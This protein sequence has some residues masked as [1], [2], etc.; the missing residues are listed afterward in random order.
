MLHDMF[1]K[2]FDLFNHIIEP[3]FR[4]P[5]HVMD[6]FNFVEENNLSMILAP[7]EHLKTVFLERYTLWKIIN[8]PNIR[9][10]LVSNTSSLAK[11]IATYPS[12]NLIEN[13]RLV[14]AF[15][16]LLDYSGISSEEFTVNR[17]TTDRNPTLYALGCFGACVGRRFDLIIVDD[18]LDKRSNSKISRKIEDWIFSELF[19]CLS[20][21]GQIVIMGTRKNKGDLY[22]RI[23]SSKGYIR[24]KIDKAI[25]GDKL[26][27]PE[28]WSMEKLMKRKAEIG[29]KSFKLD[30]LNEVR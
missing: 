24:A 3:N 18:V 9:I 27:W 22:G 28:H 8:N 26:L 14:A 19:G 7:R 13:D 21:T 30:F 11:N 17:N 6:W 12:S 29:E 1:K 2:D 15:G 10:S 25:V 5:K 20:P 16:E 4:L 23:M